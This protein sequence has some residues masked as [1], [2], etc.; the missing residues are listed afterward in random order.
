MKKLSGYAIKIDNITKVFYDAK[1]KGRVVLDNVSLNIDA[2]DFVSLLGP[3]GC[4]KTTLLRIIAGLEEKTSGGISVFGMSPRDARVKNTYGFV[5]QDPSLLEWRTV[6]ENV[7]L[8]LELK[9]VPKKKR[10]EIAREK[11][12]LVDLS[13]YEKNYPSELSGGMKQRVGIARALVTEPEILLMDEPFSALDEFTKERLYNDI[14]RIWQKTNK[15]IVFVTHNI[16]EAVK[17]S[18]KVC[19]MTTNPAKIAKV[20]EIDIP[21]PRKPNVDFI[22]KVSEI[23]EIFEGYFYEN[24]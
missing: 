18:N 3:S 14:L 24:I 6:L 17:L 5:F 8:P 12:S 21:Y 7:C 2:G 10:I 11:L 4:G 19:V 15:T 23:K 16:N 9:K 22:N 20:A 1:G 13:A